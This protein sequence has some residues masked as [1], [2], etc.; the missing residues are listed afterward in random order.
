MS[1]LRPVLERLR[2]ELTPKIDASTQFDSLRKLKQRRSVK[3]RLT[4]GLVASV[5][6]LAGVGFALSAFDADPDVP[7]RE[8]S[9][10]VLDPRIVTSFPVGPRGQVGGIAAGFGSLWVTAYGVDGGGG[11]DDAAL[12]RIDPATNRVTDEIP[13]EGVSLWETGGGD[14]A[15][16]RDAIWVAG[17]LTSNGESQGALYRIDPESLRVEGTLL[18]GEAAAADVAV[19]DDGIWVTGQHDGGAT[20]THVD[21]RFGKIDAPEVPLRGQ[22]ARQVVATDH[23]VVVRQWEWD[24]NQ[25]PCDVLTSIDP[26]TVAPIAEE[27]RGKPC[28]GSGAASLFVWGGQVWTSI[29]TGFTQ[30]DP[31]AALPT[32]SVVPFTKEDAFPRSHPVVDEHGVW[33]GAYPGGNGSSLDQLSLLDPASETIETFDL[34]VGWSAAATLDGTL[35]AL[36]WDGTV[37]RID[38]LGDGDVETE[39][40]EEPSEESSAQVALVHEEGVLVVNLLPSIDGRS[41]PRAVA[42]LGDATLAACATEGTVMGQGGPGDTSEGPTSEEDECERDAYAQGFTVPKWTHV[43]FVGEFDQLDAWFAPARGGNKHGPS[44]VPDIGG[45]PP[46]WIDAVFDGQEALFRLNYVS[47]PPTLRISDALSEVLIVECDGTATRVT[48]PLVAARADGIAVEATGRGAAAVVFRPWGLGSGDTWTVPVNEGEVLR[49]IWGNSELVARCVNGTAS[50]GSRTLGSGEA[51]V[52]TA[53]PSGVFG[54][55]FLWC[56]ME[57]WVPIE[58]DEPPTNE[59]G[60]GQLRGAIDGLEGTDILERAGYPADETDDV[61]RVRRD[62]IG[63]AAYIHSST[64]RGHACRGSGLG[65]A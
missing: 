49:P 63:V 22:T 12:L 7:V 33:F 23:A 38:L 24:G 13:L 29:L 34:Q 48:T 61:W 50:E 55:Y 1:E 15:V 28:T 9:P 62:S 59:I 42:T 58:L 56:P 53:D 2:E 51:L 44:L 31:G 25:G 27:P 64:M 6:G 37:T 18:G 39:H 5:V 16:G 41:S 60:A 11:P 45:S 54:E 17:S 21:P 8:P 40:P 65:G 3:R 14:V 52:R 10:P 32:G 35:W 4:A 26:E 47:A 20:L 19:S 46:L 57:E 30:L 36:S 43:R